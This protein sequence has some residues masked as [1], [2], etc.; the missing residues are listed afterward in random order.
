MKGDIEN[1]AGCLIWFFTLGF[2]AMLF[3]F[4]VGHGPELADI[5]LDAMR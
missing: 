4:V 5:L 1:A 2:M 3:L